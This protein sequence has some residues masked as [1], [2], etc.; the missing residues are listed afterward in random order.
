MIA[1]K[2]LHVHELQ[3][4]IRR[5]RRE[6]EVTIDSFEEIVLLLNEHGTIVR[7]NRTVEDWKLSRVTQLPGMNFHHLLHPQCSDPGC[8]LNNCWYLARNQL[9]RNRIYRIEMKDHIMERYLA[10]SFLPIAIQ[11]VEESELPHNTLPHQP[12]LPFPTPPPLNNRPS[13][14]TRDEVEPWAAAVFRDITQTKLT[15]DRLQHDASELHAIFQALPDK[16]VR[17]NPDGVILAFKEGISSEGFFMT[18]DAIGKNIRDV[19]PPSFKEEYLRAINE[20]R[21]KKSLVRLEFSYPTPLGDQSYESRFIPLWDNQIDIINRNVTENKRLLAMAQTMDLMKNL[22]Y[23]FSGIRHEIGNP[24]NA[25]KMTIS[26]LK[27]NIDSF[28]KE[29]VLEYIERTFTEISRMEYLLK[30]LKNFNLFES[31]TPM[32]V[33]FY[34]FMKSFMS[35]VEKDLNKKGIH[36]SNNV[37]SDVGFAHIDPRALHQVLLNIISNAV[38]AVEDTDFP[39]I[40]IDISRIN[41]KIRIKITDNGHGIHYSHQEEIFKPFFTTRGHGTGLGL[42]IVKKIVTGMEGTIKLESPGDTG[43]TATIDIPEGKTNTG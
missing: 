6:W 28:P 43:T 41:T 2:S 38:D 4:K 11:P 27:N 5:G 7:G 12:T 16:Y 36:I 13:T 21:I 42:N 17:L 39:E 26:V 14:E 30:N 9:Q 32:D 25:I 15:E 20:V 22:G 33:H 10:I 3:E 1:S 34:K 18:N 19:L 8:Y 29:K 31:L 35:L 24:L 23:I 40:S 37:E